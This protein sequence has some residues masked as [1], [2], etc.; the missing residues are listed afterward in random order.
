MLVQGHLIRL[1][2][3]CSVTE[4]VSCLLPLQASLELSMTFKATAQV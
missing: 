4:I 1:E 3:F 2:P